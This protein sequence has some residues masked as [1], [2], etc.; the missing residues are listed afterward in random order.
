V[1]LLRLGGAHERSI[2]AAFY[3][4]LEARF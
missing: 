2:W 1:R 3:L 4:E